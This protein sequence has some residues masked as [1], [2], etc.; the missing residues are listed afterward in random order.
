MY[1]ENVQPNAVQKEADGDNA[2][3]GQTG[4]FILLVNN[5]TGPAMMG[6][7]FLFAH[8]GWL[9]VTLA[10]LFV[11]VSASFAGTFLSYTIGTLGGNERFQ[12][13]IEFPAA[14]HHILG[15]SWHKIARILFLIACVTN[16]FAGIIEAAQSLDGFLASFLLGKTYALQILPNIELVDWHPDH[17]LIEAASS[18]IQRHHHHHH[19]HHH[20]YDGDILSDAQNGSVDI[21]EG[22]TGSC[23]PFHNAGSLLVSLGYI[24][25]AMIFLPLGLGNIKETIALQFVSFIFLLLLLSQFGEEFLDKGLHHSVPMIG[26]N[27]NALSKVAGVVLFNYAYCI[28]VPSWLAEKN[29]SVPVNS[30][31]WM[32][33]SFSTVLYLIFGYMAARSFNSEEISGNI[34][35]LLTSPKVGVT[36]Q[37][38]A[39]FFGVLIIGSGIPVFCV[40]VK[41]T[42][43]KDEI[44]SKQWARIIGGWT[45]YFVA[46]LFY[47]GDLIIT[48]LNWSGLLVTGTVAFILPMILAYYAVKLR[49]DKS[50]SL[51]KLGPE[52]I[53]SIMDR[54]DFDTN[55][56]FYRFSN[57]KEK[58][59]SEM[60]YCSSSRSSD[61][62]NDMV[63]NDKDFAMGLN[64][65]TS[66]WSLRTS[67]KDASDKQH[68]LQSIQ[69]IFSANSCEWESVFNAS[70]VPCLSPTASETDSVI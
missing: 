23:Y 20:H 39:A 47:K 5:I 13:G 57:G 44:F 53:I 8:A 10:I 64:T 3:I 38:E 22:D 54:T 51:E 27:L 14:F 34:L 19:Y 15:D 6:L 31:I 42:L 56:D 41:N 7:P 66:R 59:R 45:P 43:Y 2:S 28:T 9:P 55:N 26:D 4:S 21:A 67:Q 69:A 32:S 37:M 70:T 65:N 49:E 60:N 1:G 52:D 62:F 46:W 35:E 16:A 61:S 50:S 11:Y 18:P 63:A 24:I 12:R 36:T 40:I 25:I 33:T 58:Y 29:P 30:T 17:C 68:G 48:L